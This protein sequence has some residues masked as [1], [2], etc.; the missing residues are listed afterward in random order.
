MVKTNYWDKRIQKKYAD[1]ISVISKDDCHLSSPNYNR[2]WVFWAQGE[3]AMPP[4][5]QACFRQLTHLHDNVTLLSM[6]NLADYIDL[7]EEVYVKRRKGNIGWANF[8]DIVR[9]TLLAQY[10]GLW[11]DA[12]VWISRPIPF[13]ML[14]HNP[15]W[16]AAS[17]IA[18]KGKQFYW[19]D[20]S[21][22][23]SS[24]IMFARDIDFPLFSFVSR[25]LVAI[26]KREKE[27]PDYV[28]LDYLIYTAYRKFPII[29]NSM[30]QCQNWADNRLVLAEYM[31]KVYSYTDY[32]RVV[33]DG[34]CFKL[35][36]RTAWNKRT[37]DGS[38]T[39]YGKILKDVI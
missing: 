2:I 35:S 19:S 15:Y 31:N 38:L 1:I 39:F 13:E 18:S 27:W 25:M 26:A 30:S 4:L 9:N 16:T 34:F 20:I 28:I 36:Y 8:S 23:W 12:T 7:D 24:S 21:W 33:K 11:L 37:K 5:V 14:S 10:G 6:D 17:S 29:S 32:Q 3:R 22:N